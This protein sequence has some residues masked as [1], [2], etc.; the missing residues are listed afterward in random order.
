VT[1][2]EEEARFDEWMEDLYN[3][4]REQAIGEFAAE[5]LQSFYVD[6]PTVAEAALRSLAES[7]NLL[8]KHP[9]AALIFADIA[10]EVGLKVALLKP[11]VYGLVH[12]ESVAGIITDLVLSQTGVKRFRNLLFKIL[13]EYG[14]VD[15]KTFKRA[16]SKKSLWEEVQEIQHRR[17]NIIHQA[18]LVAER[19]SQQAIEVASSIL[20]ELFPKVVRNLGLH[21]REHGRISTISAEQEARTLEIEYLINKYSRKDK[22]PNEN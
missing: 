17:N 12:S 3:E 5:R 8:P 11:V 20:E 18:E 13:S 1:T 6:N 9:A 4:H 10:I 7:R 22:P 16:E 19:E 21:V 14:G 2:T 15:L